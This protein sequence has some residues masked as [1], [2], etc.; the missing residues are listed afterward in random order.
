MCSICMRSLVTVL[1]EVLLNFYRNNYR[2]YSDFKKVQETI[3]SVEIKNNPGFKM[4]QFTLEIYAFVY[5]SLMDDSLCMI[6]FWSSHHSKFISKCSS[7]FLQHESERKSDPVFLYCSQLFWIQY[8]FLHKGV[9]L[10]VWGTKDINIAG[11]GLTYINFA[12]LASQFKFM[13][14]MKYH[15]LC[16]GSLAN[17]VHNV[18]KNGIEKLTLQFINQHDYFSWESSPK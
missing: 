7:R 2:D 8:V 10:L 1:D 9:Q 15:I 12:S 14:I 17:T 18:E 16:L 4:S 6:W 13:D 11:S 3:G 5:Q